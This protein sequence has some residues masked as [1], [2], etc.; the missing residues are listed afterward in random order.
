MSHI[1]IV[2]SDEELR[3]ELVNLEKHTWLTLSTCPRNVYRTFP[4]GM[5]YRRH[6]WSMFPEIRKSPLWLKSMLQTGC[7][8]SLNVCRHETDMKS[9]I[10]MVPSPEEVAR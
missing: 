4:V 7:E 9:Q 8:W 2:L 6:E 3:K 1:E 5:S 10:L